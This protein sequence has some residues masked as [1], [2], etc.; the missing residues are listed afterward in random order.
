[1]NAGSA[2]AN[3]LWLAAS[4]PEWLR[5]RHSA[6]RVEATQRQLLSSYV[7]DNAATAFGRDHG[8]CGR[9]LN[10]SVIPVDPIHV[11]EDGRTVSG[12]CFTPQDGNSLLSSA[13]AATWMLYPD[14]YEK[15]IQ[16]LKPFFVDEV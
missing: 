13:A 15:R 4:L 5:F 12:Y 2:I 11:S 1:M 14:D 6:T 7:R 16:C 8:F 3:N 10:Q 9:I